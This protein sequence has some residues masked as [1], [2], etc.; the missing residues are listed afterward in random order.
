MTTQLRITV[1]QYTDK[2]RKPLNQDFHGMLVPKEPQLSTKGIAVA[3]ADG[4][5]SSDVSQIASEISVKGFLEDYYATSESWS[6]GTSV[7]RVLQATNSWLY[8]QTRNGPYRYEMDR[9]YVCTFS[10]IV[11]KSATAHIFHLGDT[12]VYRLADTSSNI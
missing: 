3:L 6:V 10:A 8:A 2:G 5:S 7:Q 4:I 9:G 11:L 12:R 1:G